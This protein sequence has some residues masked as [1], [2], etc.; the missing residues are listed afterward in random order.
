VDNRKLKSTLLGEIDESQIPD[1]YG[2]EIP[3][4][5]IHQSK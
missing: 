1:I 4:I 2:G 3:L 5:P